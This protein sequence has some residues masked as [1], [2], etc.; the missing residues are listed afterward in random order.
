MLCEFIANGSVLLSRNNTFPFVPLEFPSRRLIAFRYTF[1]EYKREIE[2]WHEKIEWE[3]NV[4][5]WYSSVSVLQI[6]FNKEIQ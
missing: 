6:K 4:A 5:K 3:K 2:M 1:L